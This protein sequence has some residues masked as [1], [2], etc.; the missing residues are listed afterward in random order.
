MTDQLDLDFRDRWRDE[1]ISAEWRRELRAV[2][3]ELG[4]KAVAADL[5]RGHSELRR[6]LGEEERHYLR[7]HEI[8]HLMRLDTTGRAL[9]CLAA[10]L[11]YEVAR[12]REFTAA[13][14]LD[15]LTAEIERNPALAKLIYEAAFGPGGRP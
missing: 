4:I 12:K 7:P 6:A 15:R 11:G 2:A 14:K 8:V 10:A 13:E 5:D 9:R 1:A 3:D